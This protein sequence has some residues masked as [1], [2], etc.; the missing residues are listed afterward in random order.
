M[1]VNAT[2]LSRASNEAAKNAAKKSRAVPK[3][4]PK[5]VCA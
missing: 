2:T 4:T 1:G 3:G 5:T